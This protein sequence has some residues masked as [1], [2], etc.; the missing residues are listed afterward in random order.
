GVVR[1]A[2]LRID[3]DRLDL[4]GAVRRH[5][6]H[7]AACGRFDRLRRKLLLC[8]LHLLLHRTDLLQEF[9]HVHSSHWFQSSRSRA[10]NVSFTS[11]RMCSSPGGSSSSVAAS[12]VSPSANATPSRRPV[13][14]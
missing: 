11:S 10:S 12:G 8:L 2:R 6:H 4:A 7:P 9:L 3:L 1:I 13:T 5:G 14:S